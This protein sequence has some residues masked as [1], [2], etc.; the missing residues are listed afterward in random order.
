[1]VAY[2]KH[3]MVIKNPKLTP[4]YFRLSLDRLGMTAEQFS[5]KV[6]VPLE[7]VSRWQKAGLP[8]PSW[9]YRVDKMIREKERPID[10]PGNQKE[11]VI[12][13]EEF[14][15]LLKDAGITRTRFKQVTGLTT[16]F[17]AKGVTRRWRKRVLSMLAKIKEEQEA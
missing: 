13:P 3:F 7:Q 16:D 10:E 12:S 15:D 9:A 11:V 14:I 5:Q 2:K 1:M 6:N 4:K 17:A 8:G